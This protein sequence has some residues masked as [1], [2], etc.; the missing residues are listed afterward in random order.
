MLSGF[1]R[2]REVV[3]SLQAVKVVLKLVIREALTVFSLVI[4][5]EESCLG[6]AGK[7]F[8]TDFFA[9]DMGKYL[10][11]QPADCLGGGAAAVGLAA[12]GF[13]IMAMGLA[14]SSA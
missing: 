11:S 10:G 4:E 7:H 6:H 13:G 1:V 9:V 5:S 8:V 3:I 2:R 14:E 12:F